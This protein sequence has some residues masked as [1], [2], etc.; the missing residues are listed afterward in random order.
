MKDYQIKKEQQ[1]WS[2]HKN[3]KTWYE[4]SKYQHQEPVV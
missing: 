2:I 1:K 3:D 4:N